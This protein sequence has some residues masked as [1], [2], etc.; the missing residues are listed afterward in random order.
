MPPLGKQCALVL[1]TPVALHRLGGK[2]DERSYCGK[3]FKPGEFLI[4]RG[5]RGHDGRPLG[6]TSSFCSYID[7]RS[8]RDEDSEK[9]NLSSAGHEYP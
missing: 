7:T 2:S 9:K 6:D 3:S 5:S 1:G 4:D 8:S